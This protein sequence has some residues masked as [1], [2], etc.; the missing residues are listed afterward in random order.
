W[1][2]LSHHIPCLL[3]LP[4]TTKGG[5][6]DVSI[7]SPATELDFRHQFGSEEDDILTLD[8]RQFLLKRA[9]R[10]LQLLHLAEQRLGDLVAVTGAHPASM[11]QLAVLVIAHHQRANGAA[12]DRGGDIAGDN[13]LLPRRAF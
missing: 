13:E 1:T 7:S 10:D 11:L 8:R 12:G 5:V 6:S 3:V 2:G 9:L 4:H